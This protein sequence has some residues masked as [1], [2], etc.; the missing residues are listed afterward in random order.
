MEKGFVSMAV[1]MKLIL[2]NHSFA[3]LAW[4]GEPVTSIHEEENPTVIV[5]GECPDF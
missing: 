5:I 2:Q 1:S 3:V 4:V